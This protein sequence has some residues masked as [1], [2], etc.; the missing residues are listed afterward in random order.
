MPSGRSRIE[1]C[2]KGAISKHAQRKLKTARELLGTASALF[3]YP[4]NMDFG[5]DSSSLGQ[6]LSVPR[7]ARMT[8]DLR[9]YRTSHA[10]D[11]VHV[12]YASTAHHMLHRRCAYT[13]RLYQFQVPCITYDA[14]SGST[15]Q[16]TC[17][18]ATRQ[19]YAYRDVPK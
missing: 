10:A 2:A 13:I 5:S 19:R 9:Q 12:T 15:A 7:I 3:G 1:A 6:P 11:E 4:S 8:R 18:H 17:E 14:A 16:H